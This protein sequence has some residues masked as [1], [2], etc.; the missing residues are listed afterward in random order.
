MRSH[1]FFLAFSVFVKYAE[2]GLALS[3]LLQSGKKAKNYSLLL[4]QKYICQ[5]CI[6]FKK[7]GEKIDGLHVYS[8][9]ELQEKPSKLTGNE[10][11]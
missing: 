10:V 3:Q 9:L 4:V 1:V 7:P 2:S 6:T 5:G 11:S 8:R